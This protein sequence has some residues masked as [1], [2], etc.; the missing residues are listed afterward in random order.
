M[1]NAS[2]SQSSDMPLHSDLPLRPCVGI[3]L[4]NKAGLVWTGRRIQKPQKLPAKFIWQMPQGGIDTGEEPEQAALRELREETGISE[5]ITILKQSSHWYSYELPPD[6]IGTGL[7]GKYRGQIQKWFAVAFSGDEHDIDLSEKEGQQA[8]FDQW[9]W[10]KA[11]EL[12]SLIVH[13]KRPVYNSVIEEF[14]TF[15]SLSGTL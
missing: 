14:S 15:F 5:H 9:K 7:K 12:P 1:T 3:M 13:F 6:I 8:E 10:R 2:F 4:I 11:C